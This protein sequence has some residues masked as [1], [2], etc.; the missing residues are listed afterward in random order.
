[1][2]EN[3]FNM[4]CKNSKLPYIEMRLKQ[5]AYKKAINTD[6]KFID[7]PEYYDNYSW[8]INQYAGRA[9]DAQGLINKIASSV[10]TITSMLAII[11]VLS[12]IAIIVTVVGTVVENLLHM[13]TNYHDVKKE[14]D[15]VPYDRRSGYF[16]RIFY[17]SRYAADIKST[18]VDK[19]LM[20]EYEDTQNKK[21]SIIKKYARKMIPWALSADL[22]FYVA[23]TFVILNIVYGICIGDISTVGAYVTLMLAVDKLKDSMND[24]FYYIKDANRLCIYAKRIRKFFDT[25]SQIENK[26]SIGQLPASGSYDVELENVCFSYENSE[27]SLNNLNLKINRGEKVAIVGENGVGKST[28]VKLLLRLYDVSSGQIKIN[29]INIKEYNLEA[30]RTKIGFAFQNANIYALSFKNNIELYNEVNDKNLEFIVKKFDFDKIFEKSNSN[31]LSNV[32]REFDEKGI[33]LSGGEIQKIGIA[34][35][36]TSDF[37]LL[38]FD[39]PSSALDPIAEYNM[40]KMIFDASNRSTTIMIAHRLSTIRNADKIALVDKGRVLE[41]GTHDEFMLKQGKYY[42]MFTKQAENYTI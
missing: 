18:N 10:I 4:F 1:M 14:E 31:V 12:P 16:H 29:G 7:N 30:L 8:A 33:M 25:E 21:I 38:I 20:R 42:E 23:R 26:K 2:F 6:Y 37:G 9:Q 11:T 41:I 34:R 13:R 17:T 3:V 27:F 19:Y 15:I 22:T 36:F 39:E 32:T 35:L 28:L 40:T 5:E 24:M